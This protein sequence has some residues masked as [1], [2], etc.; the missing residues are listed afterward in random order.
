MSSTGLASPSANPPFVLRADT[1][2]PDRDG[3]LIYGLAPKQVPL[4]GG[5]LWIAPPLRRSG[6]IDSGGFPT[7]PCSG[8]LLH[9]FTAPLQSDPA[10]TP[11]RPV[12]AQFWYRDPQSP[13]LTNL[14]NALQFTVLP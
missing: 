13:G 4:N 1:V 2:I 6:L 12:Y 3:L 9:D 14:T 7:T 5:T 8:L 11:G 10:L